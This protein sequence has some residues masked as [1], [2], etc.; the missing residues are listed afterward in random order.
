MNS[1]Y[2]TISPTGRLSIP[3]EFRKVLGLERGGDVIVELDGR[4]IHIRTVEEAVVHAQAL[5]RR[6]LGARAQA[7]VDEFIAERRQEA[8]RE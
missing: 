5:T 8:V 2:A 3:A 1:K 4:E 7:S 6:V